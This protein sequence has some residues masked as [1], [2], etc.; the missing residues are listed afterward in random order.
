MQEQ[1]FENP[2][3]LLRRTKGSGLQ[4]MRTIDGVNSGR[5]AHQKIQ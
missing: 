1:G 4:R 5:R 3:G 2:L